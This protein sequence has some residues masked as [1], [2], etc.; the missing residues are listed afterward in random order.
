MSI[1]YAVGVVGRGSET[2]LQVIENVSNLIDAQR[3]KNGSYD[4]S[5]QRQ[6]YKYCCIYLCVYK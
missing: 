3:V 1:F 2:Q 5:M 6:R 4:P